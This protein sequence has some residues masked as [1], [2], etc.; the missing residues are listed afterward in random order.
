[1]LLNVDLSKVCYGFLGPLFAS[2]LIVMKPA[3][4]DIAIRSS[5]LDAEHGFC[6]TLYMKNHWVALKYDKESG[7]ICNSLSSLDA[8]ALL[9][10]NVFVHVLGATF[11][12]GKRWK[13]VIIKHCQQQ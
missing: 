5:A 3:E 9:T 7:Q 8:D 6:T 12:M 2:S 4:R 10:A 1:M 11:P 13:T